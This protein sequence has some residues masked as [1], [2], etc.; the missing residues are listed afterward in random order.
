MVILPM[1]N[2]R[3]GSLGRSALVWMHGIQSKYPEWVND[4]RIKSLSFQLNRI[5]TFPGC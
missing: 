3:I 5:F 2:G 1:Y 4:T